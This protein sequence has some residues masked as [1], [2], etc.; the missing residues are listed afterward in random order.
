MP[1]SPRQRNLAESQGFSSLPECRTQPGRLIHVS[2][3]ETH[4]FCVV[5]SLPITAA[6]PPSLLSWRA[7]WPMTEWSPIH[8]SA[9]TMRS[10]IQRFA[11]P[12]C[13]RII[14]LAPSISPT[15]LLYFPLI[16]HI[17]VQ[18]MA[19]HRAHAGFPP[20]IFISLQQTSSPTCICVLVYF[21]LVASSGAHN[22]FRLRSCSSRFSCF[23]W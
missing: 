15:P 1:L 23:R 20:L 13:L 9:E 22:P 4:H 11:V 17:L 10:R 2:L 7:F 18:C 16:L 8:P 12:L 14:L 21:E 3:R 5:P 6:A 19:C